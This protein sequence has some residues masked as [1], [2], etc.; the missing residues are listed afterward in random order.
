MFPHS[1]PATVHES[2]VADSFCATSSVKDAPQKHVTRMAD[3]TK[4][5]QSVNYSTRLVHGSCRSLPEGEVSCFDNALFIHNVKPVKNMS[6][7]VSAA[8][9]QSNTACDSILFSERHPERG[10]TSVSES[11]VGQYGTA[12]FGRSEWSEH[13]G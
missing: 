3:G 6:H 9:F 10:G 7:S 12:S 8:K 13:G 4:E 5:I 11:F 2:A 1:Y